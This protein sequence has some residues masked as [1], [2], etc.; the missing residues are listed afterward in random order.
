MGT[1]K[2]PE[3][4]ISQTKCKYGCIYYEKSGFKS[5]GD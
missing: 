3:R 5:F 2:K 1:T 4:V